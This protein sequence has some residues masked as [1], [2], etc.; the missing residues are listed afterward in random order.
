MPDGSNGITPRTW[1]LVMTP[2]RARILRRLG[3]TGD[4][5][6]ELVLRTQAPRLRALLAGEAGQGMTALA[7]DD[8]EFVG[9]V[10]L[11]LDT[12]RRAGEFEG[13]VLCAAPEVLDSLRRGL[14]RLLWD[15]VVAEVPQDLLH[16]SE[17]ELPG[18]LSRALEKGTAR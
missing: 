6:A 5:P 8:H 13:L 10:G 11:L 7:S 16:L 17:A 4:R 18:A 15:R 12:H 2:T 9:Q 3:E 1:A 14:P